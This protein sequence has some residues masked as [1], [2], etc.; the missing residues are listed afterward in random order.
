MYW[1]EWSVSILGRCTTPGGGDGSHWIWGLVVKSCVGCD[2]EEINLYHHE[3]SNP[4][5]PVIHRLAWF[6]S[7]WTASTPVSSVCV[8]LI[9]YFTR[10]AE[11]KSKNCV[12][13]CFV[14]G[15]G[16]VCVCEWEREREERVV[17]FNGAVNCDDCLASAVVN[18]IS[19]RR[20]G[21]FLLTGENQTTR[22]KSPRATRWFKYDRDWFV[23]KQAALRSSC[24]TLREWSHNLHPPSFSG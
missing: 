7:H 15:V 9:L 12:C 5:S 14:F 1:Y 8:Y 4:G 20:K 24:A 18:E 2:G 13:L 11:S 16:D 6:H 3:K 21:G 23:C 19:V 17:L 22:I 10:R